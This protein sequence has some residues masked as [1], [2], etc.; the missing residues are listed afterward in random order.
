MLEGNSWSKIK[1]PY[2][3]L[4]KRNVSVRETCWSR[5]SANEQEE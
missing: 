5:M 4:I 1:I 2:C 3:S